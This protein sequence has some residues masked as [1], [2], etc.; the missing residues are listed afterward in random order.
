MSWFE[1]LTIALIL[2]GAAIMLYAIVGARK[3]L[4]IIGMLKIRKNWVFLIVL[5]SIFFLGYLVAAGLVITDN[6]ALV[7]LVSG[8]IFC[9]GA[10]FVAITV[11]TGHITIVAIQKLNKKANRIKN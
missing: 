6:T 8:F 7:V 5:M 11:H 4:G 10:V 2:A 9:F 3:I 1:Y